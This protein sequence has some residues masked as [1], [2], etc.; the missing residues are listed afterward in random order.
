MKKLDTE[1]YKHFH[2]RTSVTQIKLYLNN[3]IINIATDNGSLIVHQNDTQDTN[4][5]P[6]LPNN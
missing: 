5:D 6:V 4:K 1:K 3:S 2:K